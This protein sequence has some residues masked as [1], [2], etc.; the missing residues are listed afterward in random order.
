MSLASETFI[1]IDAEQADDCLNDSLGYPGFHGVAYSNIACDKAGF[2]LIKELNEVYRDDAP[3]H[4]I[5]KLASQGKT[6]HHCW[7][8]GWMC[9]VKGKS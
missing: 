9:E 8:K 5:A 7:L 2:T 4:L 1:P 6:L 3:K